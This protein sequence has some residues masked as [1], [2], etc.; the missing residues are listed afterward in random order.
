MRAFRVPM[1]GEV[2]RDFLPLLGYERMTTNW[3]HTIQPETA[4]D[5]GDADH[6]TGSHCV[7]KL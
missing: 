5:V 3:T 1:M 7:R 4:L 6:L 2:M